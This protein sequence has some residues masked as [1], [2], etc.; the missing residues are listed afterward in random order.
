M[1]NLKIL[2]HH[3]EKNNLCQQNTKIRATC[4]DDYTT[5]SSSQMAL[6]CFRRLT[7]I[8]QKKKKNPKILDN[9]TLFK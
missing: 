7:D 8:N 2:S 6:I 9:K 5:M 4:Q 1:A 3:G